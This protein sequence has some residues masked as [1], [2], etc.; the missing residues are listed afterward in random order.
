MGEL[1]GALVGFVVLLVVL[2]ALRVW[3]QNRIE[4][5][6][7]DMVLALIP[8]ALWLF[9]SGRIQELTVGEVKIVAAIKQ[10]ST[11][12]VA[13]QVTRL[14]V[15]LVRADPKEG[16][17]QLAELKRKGAQALSFQLGYGGYYGPVLRQYL[18]ELVQT[19]AFRYVVI[20][21]AD[22]SLF[23]LLDS[24]Q[25]TSL[26]KAGSGQVDPER[27]A[28][29]LNRSST[30]ELSSLPGFIPAK[31]ALQ[32]T[33]ETRDAL[34]RMNALDVQSLP[35]VDDTGRFVGVVDRSKLSASMLIDI[36]AKV[37]R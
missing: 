28:E 35:V 23:G 32:K 36:A 19:P 15:D 4:V 27:F 8:I 1:F 18:E 9:T 14:P 30:T 6:T 5:K 11:S 7:S 2:V 21:R 24:R 12:P 17:S 10:A 22:G 31:S 34:E 33:S 29:W 20:N 16:L 37:S 3:T 13:S 26:L 25:L